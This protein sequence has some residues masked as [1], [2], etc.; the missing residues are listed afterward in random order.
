MSAFFVEAFLVEAFFV[1][2]FF[3]GAFFAGAFFAGALTEVVREVFA[4]DAA[5]G[6]GFAPAVDAARRRIA[7]RFFMSAFEIMPPCFD[8]SWKARPTS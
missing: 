5:F 8:A 1:E 2:D 3:A 6:V 7:S 4:G